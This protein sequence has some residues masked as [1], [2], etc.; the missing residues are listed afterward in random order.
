MGCT[1]QAVSYGV[2][3]TFSYTGAPAPALGS[4]MDAAQTSVEVTSYYKDFH[5][6][7][8]LLHSIFYS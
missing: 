1:S 5:N 3:E 7:A 8:P 6:R 2:L 4:I